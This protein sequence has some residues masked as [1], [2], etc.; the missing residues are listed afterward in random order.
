MTCPGHR[1][2]Q[3]RA[4]ASF[5]DDPS[6]AQPDREPR[7]PEAPEATQAAGEVRA[8]PPPATQPIAA[9]RHVP[10]MPAEVLAVLTPR[11][12]ETYLDCT[13]GRGGHALL[14][15]GHL[16]PTGR[17]IL[18]DADPGNLAASTERIRELAGPEVVPVRGNFA[19]L[20]RRLAE[21]GFAADTVLA[22]LGFASNQVDDAERGFSF[23]RDGP[24]DMR[25][26]PAVPT[27]AAE[28]V[29]SLSEEELAN[30]IFEFGEDSAS[31][32]IAR[33]LVQVRRTQPI[34]RTVQLAE[35]VREA[36][37]GRRPRSASQ[38]TGKGV[39]PATRTFQALRIAVNDELGSLM[40]L[41]ATV[42][43]DARSAA[44][45]RPTR[46]LR[47]GAR[48]AIISFHSL[49]DRPV[50]QAFGDLC[51]AGLA[52]DLSKGALAARPEEIEANPRSRS[53]KLRAVQIN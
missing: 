24:L 19:E 25:M 11:A 45:G 26:D 34:T 43:E 31:R 38:A 49:E 8:T 15:A 50:K 48:I 52:S 39:H 16:G 21:L 7:H 6:S 36:V 53:A 12:G 51:K 10:V 29:A 1:H 23:M 20:P 41:L 4:L 30:L 9:P 37:E 13:A 22:D 2:G 40:A 18:N 44:A 28:L 3:R 17:V 42:A 33:K 5:V 32:R 14:I 47:R 46:W 35:L 27:S